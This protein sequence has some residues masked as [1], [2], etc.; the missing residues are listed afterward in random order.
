M[1]DFLDKLGGVIAAAAAVV[2]VGFLFG[3]GFFAVFSLYT[4]WVW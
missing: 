1:M 2:V 3:T 4:E